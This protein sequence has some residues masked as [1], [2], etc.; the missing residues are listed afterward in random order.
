MLRNKIPVG[1]LG[2]TGS[3]GQKFFSLLANHPWF[4]IT[5]L[6]ASKQSAGEK[7]HKLVKINRND[8][9]ENSYGN[10]RISECQ[11]DLPC[12]IVFSALDASVAGE[13]ETLFAENGYIVV[14]N[15]R[16]HRF[17]EK[18]P[19]LIPEI[20][21]DHLQL[22]A[23]QSW[24]GGKIV[25]NPNCSTTG[26]AIGLKPLLDTFGIEAVHVVTMQ[27]ISGAGYP[28]L[29]AMD[30]N[31]NVIPF[32]G[33]EE[34]KME[35]EPQKI[36]GVYR[37]AKIYQ[38]DFTLSASCNRVAVLE[39]HLESIS[40]KLKSGAS[41]DRI[42]NAWQTYSGLPQKLKLPSA[43]K[44]LIHYFSDDDLPQPRRQR[45]LENGMAVSI[46]RLRPC[47]IF[48]YKF[49]LLVHNTLRGAAGGAIL[50]AELM[51]AQNLIAV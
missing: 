51:V 18:V 32:I 3:V 17:H 19:L 29:P 10:F 43:P 20:N 7:Y 22:L 9:N 1:I 30:I 23:H 47:P 37:D 39:G 42:I 4:E 45:D 15:A 40:V 36:L 5:A 33:G 8:P 12:R 48:D 38:A 49:T 13:I 24:S 6:A 35:R 31:D 27:A 41:E 11:P 46:G 14:S 21:S 44:Q 25:T 28:G 26:L 34:D 16:N 50:N 2:A